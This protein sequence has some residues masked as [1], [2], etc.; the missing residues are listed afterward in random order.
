MKNRGWAVA[1]VTSGATDDATPAAFYAHQPN[2]GMTYEIAMDGLRSGFDFIGGSGMHALVK[3]G[4]PS[5]ILDRY[6]EAGF[7]VNL[8]AEE[9]RSNVGKA[10]QMVVI[11]ENPSWTL[12]YAIDKPQGLHLEEL[13]EIGMEQ[14]KT[15]NP[16]SF[17]MMIEEGD[18]DH[19]GHNAD[20]GAIIHQTIDFQKSIALAYEF[21]KQHPN[22]TLIVVTA[23]HDTSGSTFGYKKGNVSNIACQKM[24]KSAFGDYCRRLY[25]S[26][27]NVEWTDMQEILKQNFGFGDK[28]Q[29]K[30]SDSDR[31]HQKFEKMFKARENSDEKGLYE[32]FDSFTVDVFK[33]FGQYTGL[34]YVIGGHTGN[35]VPV[36]AIGVGSEN[37]DGFI[38]NT[39]IPKIILRATE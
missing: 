37:F 25:A 6:R 13:V 20:G 15:N 39:D 34:G 19:A 26:G 16:D 4:K 33:T 11:S 28:I 23:D 2:R 12:G 32:S 18:I 36:Y 10:G 22:E 14:V 35:A 1:L 5:D 29:L 27:E 21:Y 24:S 7:S 30:D 9:A 38:D 3:D 17:F 8:G 31:L